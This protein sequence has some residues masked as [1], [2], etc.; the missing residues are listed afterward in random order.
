M[1]IK[2][3][4]GS[5]S[6]SI[7]LTS[8]F[9]MHEDFIIF[10]VTGPLCVEFT[11]HW[12][13]PLTKAGAAELWCFL[14]SGPEKNGWVNNRDAADLR[15]HRSHYNVTVMVYMKTGCSTSESDWMCPIDAIYI[16]VNTDPS[17]GLLPDRAPNHHVSQCWLLLSDVLWHWPD[18]NFPARAQAGILYNEF[19]I[20]FLKVLPHLPGDNECVC[21]VGELYASISV[22][23]AV[24]LY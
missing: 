21:S 16:W 15:R 17:K 6:Y 20:V 1:L 4:E 12:W 3:S 8:I 13:I 9:S 10:R 5:A 19:K 11:G 7:H 23:L 24:P 2:Q 14:W 22:H 18:N